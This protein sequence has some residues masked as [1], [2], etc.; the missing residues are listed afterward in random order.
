AATLERLT[1]R[2]GVVGVPGHGPLNT[3]WQDWL[4]L[5]SQ[6]TA[7]RLIVA[8]ALARRESRGAHWRRDFPVPAA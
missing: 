3:A 4:N 8:S 6:L 5:D 7:A 1:E 2:L